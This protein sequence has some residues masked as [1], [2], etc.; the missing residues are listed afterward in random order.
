MVY[1]GDDPDNRNEEIRKIQQKG[2]KTSERDGI[3]IPDGSK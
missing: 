1:L 3:K 2:G